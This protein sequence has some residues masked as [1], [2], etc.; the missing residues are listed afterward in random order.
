[1]NKQDVVITGIGLVSSLGE[2]PDAHWAALSQPGAKPVLDEA[3]FAPFPVHP[4][5]ALSLDAQ[6]PK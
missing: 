6:I 2:G 5:P 1:M 3:A 4:L